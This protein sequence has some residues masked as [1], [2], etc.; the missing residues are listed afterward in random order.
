MTLMSQPGRR[1]SRPT[2]SAAALR[3]ASAL[4]CVGLLTAGSGCLPPEQAVEAADAA[5]YSILEEKQLAALGRAE[6]FT[7]DTP[8]DELRRKLL[9]DQNLPAAGPASFGSLYLPP[10]PKQPDGV[11]DGPDAL[12]AGAREQIVGTRVA[13]TPGV[14]AP[15]LSTDLFLVQLGPRGTVRRV[16]AEPAGIGVTLG[17]PAPGDFDAIEPLVI[18]LVEALTIG[19]RNSRDYQTQKELLYQTALSLD[20]ERDQFEFRF[21]AT[22]DADF[23]SELE[24]DDTSGVVVSPAI[25]VNKLFKSGAILTSRIGLDL[26]KLLSGNEAESLGLLADASITIPLLQGAGVEV[27]AEPLQQAERDVIYAIWDFERFKQTFAV[28]VIGRYFNV[29][30]ALDRIANARGTYERLK[31]NSRRSYALFEAGEL[32]AVQVDQVLSNELSAYGRLIRAEQ[33]YEDQL[34]QFKL[35]L[36]LPPDAAVLLDPEELEELQPLATRVLGD[37]AEGGLLR[38]YTN[39]LGP[40]TTQP[41]TPPT[42]PPEPNAALDEQALEEAIDPT[43]Q[44]G[45]TDETNLPGNPREIQR[46]IEGDTASPLGVPVVPLDLAFRSKAIRVALNNRLDLAATYGEVVDAQRRIVVAANGLEGVIDLVGSVNVGGGRGALSGNLPDTNLRFDEGS[47]AAGLRLS[48]P[49]E[50]TAERNAYRN[51]LIAMERAVR[52]AQEAEDRVKLNIID[53]L[54]NIRVAAED[55]RVQALAIE[56]AQRRLNLANELLDLGRGET[57]DVTEAEA[58]LVDAQN[59]FTSSL[60]DLR[61]AELTL[62]RDLGLLRVSQDGLYEESEF[63]ESLLPN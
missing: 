56:V 59:A 35:F 23:Q 40:P 22:L 43:E 14:N 3:R 5:A 36:G 31:L 52:T 20:L 7:I 11:T 62:Q 18:S 45:P 33:A 48:L 4:A 39:S 9:L 58:D 8:E 42:T 15:S 30:Q 6:P 27:V 46:Q 1:C 37:V 19:A 17:P 47:Y 32:P 28:D 51:A 21:N 50:R 41:T 16:V 60:V 29:L 49:I 54:R 12:P 2:R 10:V 13:P 55:L 57:R 61:V 53:A 26:A 38:Q 44:P 24:G 34:D 63:F 25:G